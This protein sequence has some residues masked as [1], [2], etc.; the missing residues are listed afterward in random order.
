MAF[1][2]PR[3]RHHPSLASHIPA[4]PLPANVLNPACYKKITPKVHFFAKKFGGFKYYY[5]L[6]GRIYT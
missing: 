1:A 6:C 2:M 5:Y 3:L 4:F